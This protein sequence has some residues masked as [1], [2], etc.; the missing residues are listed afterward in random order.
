[1]ITGAAAAQLIKNNNGPVITQGGKLIKRP[2]G[3]TGPAVQHH[4][5]GAAAFAQYAV[6]YFTTG[7]LHITFPG[8]QIG[9]AFATDEGNEDGENKQAGEETGRGA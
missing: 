9:S 3:A 4:Y 8:L 6:P 1:M 2:A 5:R 7:Y